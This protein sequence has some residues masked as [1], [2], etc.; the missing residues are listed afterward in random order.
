[1][2]DKISV[3][4]SYNLLTRQYLW[5]IMQIISRFHRVNC[6]LLLAINTVRGVQL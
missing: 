2:T 1:M 3:H 6:N 4:I 5:I